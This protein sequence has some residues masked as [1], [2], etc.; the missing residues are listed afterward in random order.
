MEFNHQ[1]KNL[2]KDFT[3]LKKIKVSLL[4][5][6]ASQ[7]LMQAFYGYEYA[8]NQ[9][10]FEPY[11][12]LVN[13]HLMDYSSE[14]HKNEGEITFVYKSAYLKGINYSNNCFN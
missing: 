6:T 8:Y 4:S 2:K 9:E 11:F 1:K 12:I 5:D 13:R 3:G 14:L 10:M 7:L